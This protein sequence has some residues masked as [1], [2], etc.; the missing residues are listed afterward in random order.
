VIELHWEIIGLMPFV[1]ITRPRV[2]SWRYLPGFLIQSLRATRQAKRSGGSLSVSVLRDA[3]RAFWTRTV[4]RDEAAMR[5]FMHSGVHRGIMGTS[6]AGAMRPPSSV[7]FRMA[8]NRHPDRRRTAACSK[9]AAFKGQSPVG[10]ATPVRD[11]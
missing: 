6:S 8:A 2:R 11:P 7:G 9:R 1:S 3:D 10:C 4:W 5:S